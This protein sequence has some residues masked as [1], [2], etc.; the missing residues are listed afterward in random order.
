MQYTK[1]GTTGL[2]VSPIAIGAMTYGDPGRGHPV[3]SLDEDDSRPLIRYALEAGI[4]FFDTANM[5]SYGSSEE[6]LGRALADFADR[7]EVVIATKLRHPMRPGPNGKGL[8]RKAVMDDPVAPKRAGPGYDVTIV[9]FF[10]YNCPYCRRMEPVLDG[11]LASDPKVRIVYRDWPIFGPASREAARAAI[12][13]QWQGRHAAFHEALLT[14]PAR[15]DSA[16]IRA[17]ATRAANGG[18]PTGGVDHEDADA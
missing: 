6:I 15:L 5:Y 7:D 3:W 12:A 10:D 2:D 13:S 17:A 16:G 1:L 14:S 9:E 4:N 11:L 8:S 18:P